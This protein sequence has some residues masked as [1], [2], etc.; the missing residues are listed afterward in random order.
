MS[1]E[2]LQNALPDRYRVVR[3][4]GRGGMATVYLAE[5]IQEGRN[6][7]VKVLSGELG[8]SLDATR[9]LREI[10]IA[11]ELTHPNILQAYD[12]GSGAGVVYY[13]MPFIEGRSVRARLDEER[14]FP[15]D[16]AV[17]ITCEVCDALAFAHERGIVHRD[18]KPENILLQNGHAIVADFG[19]ARIIAEQGA[20]L[21]QTGLSLGTAQ[22]MSP[23]QASAEKVDGRTDVYALGCVLYEMLV[24]EPPFTGPNAMA[25]L[26]RSVTQP[27]P[28]IR[29]VR[30]SV[31][32]TVEFAIMRALEKV[33]VDRFASATEFKEALLADDGSPSATRQRK[34]YTNAY[35]GGNWAHKPWWRRPQNLTMLALAAVLVVG[36][37]SWYVFH[38]K[39]AAALAAAGPTDANHLAVMYFKDTSPNGSL[40]HIADGL[41]ESLIDELD[42]VATLDVVS[43]EGVRPFRGATI[44]PDSVHKVL[45]VGT[46]VEGEVGPGDRGARVTV[47]LFDA[48]GS[49][50]TN[51]TFDL[52]TA[53][54]LVARDSL[55]RRVADF[56]RDKVGLEVDVKNSRMRA[57]SPQA[58]IQVQRAE[59]QIKD[60]DSLIAVRQVDKAA[61]ALDSADAALMKAATL[62]PKWAQPLMGRATVARS[63]AQM[64]R[65]RPELANAVLDSGRVFAE[66]AVALDPTSAD[67]HE[68]NGEIAF[69]HVQ[70]LTIPLG[71]EWD[72]ELER[73]DTELR[74]AVALNPQQATAFAALSDVANAQKHGSDAL[75]FAQRAY[76]ADAYLHN[77]NQIVGKLFWGFYDNE[78]FP[79]ARKWCD[80]GHKRFP[81]SIGFVQCRLYLM[82]VKGGKPDPD[83]AWGL[84]DS[85][86]KLSSPAT[87]AYQDHFART[88]V[89]GV[90]GKAGRADSANHVLVAARAN[91]DVDPQQEIIGREI[92]MRLMYGD[93]KTAIDRLGDYLLVH[94]DHRKGLV[95]Q[96]GW[97]WKDP[98]VQN[99]P[100]FQKLIAGAQ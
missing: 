67:A 38:A 29:V 96:T 35:R 83:E 89:G 66:R 61:P 18:I 27:V 36:G 84:A 70:L 48:S 39:R 32:E 45:K 59:K 76:A 12:S 5:D 24:G 64:L 13:V 65:E 95:N 82:M 78:R 98:R 81:R 4:I 91:R 79:D 37:S 46:I 51:A 63:R 69:A 40:R 15:V 92:M 19:I 11:G 47:R 52:D 60:A 72:R 50:L 33:P 43:R 20:T 80:E 30:A 10:K 99:D 16:E 14:Q 22:Y 21:T 62:D 31:P 34:A 85:I 9:F 75:D 74:R 26:A 1:L 88:L 42:R 77:A 68:V 25:V 28:S 58:W 8:S 86:R 56:L 55:T 54:V 94:P 87:L 23:E 53:N 97:Y 17:R 49:S 90:L 44:T 7:A 41:T 100:R 57:S 93:Y 6:V 71:A 73:A 2:A 3:E